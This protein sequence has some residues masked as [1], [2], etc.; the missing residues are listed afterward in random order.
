MMTPRQHAILNGV[1]ETHI[2][3][4]QPVGSSLIRRRYRM[5]Y[6]PA[7]VRND[8]GILEEKGY[9]TQPHTSSGRIPTD[10][11]YRYYVDEC[12]E[13]SRYPEE[14]FGQV[15]GGIRSLSGTVEETELFLEESSRLLASFTRETSLILVSEPGK[16]TSRDALERNRLYLQGSSHFLDKPEFQDVQKVRMLFRA[17]EE[18]MKLIEWITGQPEKNERISICIG[19]ENAPPAFHECAVIST[20]YS[21]G[22]IPAGRIALVGP[23]RMRYSLTIPLMQRVARILELILNERYVK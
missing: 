15:E 5:G 12:L 4:A 1:I 23:K 13:K 2:E 11:G 7:T 16:G 17:F 19:H 10:L 20:R 8:M 21:I 22:S 3:T 18:K 6:S 9:L 14:V